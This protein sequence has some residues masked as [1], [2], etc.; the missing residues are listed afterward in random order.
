MKKK[1]ESGFMLVETLIV[2]TVILGTLVFLFVQFQTVNKSYSDSF[3]Y[4]TVPDLYLANQIREYLNENN[5][6][7]IIS[8]LQESDKDYLELTTC[9]EDLIKYP[10]YCNAF[11]K[12]WGVKTLLFTKARTDSLYNSLL[13]TRELDENLIQFIGKIKDKNSADNLYRIIVFYEDKTFATLTISEEKNFYTFNK[14][15]T[16]ETKLDAL[17]ARNLF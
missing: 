10:R 11:L 14:E 8:Y 12:Q 9:P 13:V 2:S 3:Q 6:D 17:K 15:N 4:N 16:N 7:D 1:N 5:L